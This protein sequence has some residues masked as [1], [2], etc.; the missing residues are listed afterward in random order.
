MS[1][2]GAGP[3]RTVPRDPA[4]A[5]GRQPGDTPRDRERIRPDASAPSIS[6]SAG[7]PERMRAMRRADREHGLP[8]MRAAGAKRDG[9]GGG[10]GGTAPLKSR[11]SAHRRRPR[12]ADGQDANGHLELRFDEG[13]VPLRGLRKGAPS[14]ARDPDPLL[15]RE[16]RPPLEFAIHGP[17]FREDPHACGELLEDAA[18]V[19]VPDARPDAG[20]AP[21]H[22]EFF[23]REAREAVDSGGHA[24][25]YQIEPAHPS[26]AACRPP[27]LSPAPLP[28]VF[29]ARTLPL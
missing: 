1:L 21:E 3:A 6:V 27:A 2:R 23:H 9:R 5:R 10:F 22:I 28:A 26:R 16:I 13:D 12:P 7:D 19:A 4:P 8:G 18:V 29:R 17:A 24:E 20:E 25:H 11:S 15:F 14:P